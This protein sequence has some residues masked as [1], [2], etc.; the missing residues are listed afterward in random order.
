MSRKAFFCVTC[1]AVGGLCSSA[2]WTSTG[3][4]DWRHIVRDIERHESSSDHHTAKIVRIKWLSKLRLSDMF[5]SQ[6]SA[7][8]EVVERNRRTMHVMIDAVKYL[9][10]EHM[11][12]RGHKTC[13]GK[14]YNLFALLAKYDSA[15]G[16]YL[17]A[18]NENAAQKLKC[19][20]VSAGNQKRLLSCMK[21]MIQE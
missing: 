1:I 15:A 9:S 5:D 20:L 11:A 8:N 19:N 18:I 21:Q 17:Q 4:N 7:W 13:D 10:K 12:L 16:S 3:C 2:M 6:R 14:L